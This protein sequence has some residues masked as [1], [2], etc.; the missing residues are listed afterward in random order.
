MHTENNKGN[1]PCRLPKR[2]IEVL[3]LCCDGFNYI[4]IG[5]KLCIGERTVRTYIK[6]WY[7]KLNISYHQVLLLKKAVKE[8]YYFL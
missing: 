5:D 6:N 3:I 4:E 7:K 2:E 1:K 8:G